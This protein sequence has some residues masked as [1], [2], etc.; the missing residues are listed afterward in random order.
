MAGGEGSSSSPE[1]G[2]GPH[3]VRWRGASAASVETRAP[4]TSL[5]L[6][7]LPVPG[8]SYGP[9]LDVDV[10]LGIGENDVMLLEQGPD[11]VQHF[12]ADAAD[13]RFGIADPDQ[14]LVVDAA[15]AEGAEPDARRRRI[16]DPFRLRRRLHH[17]L[18]GQRQVA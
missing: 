2:G 6:G 18:L 10:A 4:S 15:F 1:R 14:D 12:R 3:E 17:Q 13:P 11:A 7:P 16:L 8:R 9:I 5:R